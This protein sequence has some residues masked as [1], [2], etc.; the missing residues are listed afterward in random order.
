MNIPATFLLFLSFLPALCFSQ[1][2]EKLA[3]V[4]EERETLT[5]PRVGVILAS[6]HGTSL[7]PAMGLLSQDSKRIYFSNHQKTSDCMG[8]DVWEVGLDGS[9]APKR[10]AE[11][12]CVLQL[13]L[14][15]DGVIVRWKD[16]AKNQFFV[17]AVQSENALKS[18]AQIQGPAFPKGQW[19]WKKSLL[20]RHPQG[21][22]LAESEW[23]AQVYKG[24]RFVGLSGKAEDLATTQLLSL[25]L[26][27]TDNAESP[28]LFTFSEMAKDRTQIDLSRIVLREFHLTTYDWALITYRGK[29]S[30]S[31]MSGFFLVDTSKGVVS[32]SLGAAQPYESAL[33]WDAL[34]GKEWAVR[35]LDYSA[36]SAMGMLFYDQTP[37]RGSEHRAVSYYS[38]WLSS[39]DSALFTRVKGLPALEVSGLSVAK[40]GLLLSFANEQTIVWF[41]KKNIFDEAK[42]KSRRP[43]LREMSA[44]EYRT[45]LGETK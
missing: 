15:H 16:T 12:G 11:I 9:A 23:L 38:P 22:R 10:L 37:N 27:E 7:Q 13:S 18:F 42:F 5:R 24:F 8:Q 4:K 19:Q 35:D 28:L 41:G 32:K 2:G 6:L 44:G 43:N 31:Q 20:E 40:E 30:D 36:L 3:K 25:S 34:G 17:H 45:L 14:G 21:I 1:G 33:E 39:D 26:K 29:N